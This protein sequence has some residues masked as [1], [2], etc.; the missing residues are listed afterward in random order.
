MNFILFALLLSVGQ[1]L[2]AAPSGQL[3]VSSDGTGSG[4]ITSSPSGI[5]C[6]NI[7]SASYPAG[8]QVSL[9]ANPASG[10]ILA[11]WNGD[12]FG[13]GV[14]LISISSVAAQSAVAT[15]NSE[16][17]DTIPLTVSLSGL[18]NGSV[19]SSPSGINCG[20]DCAGSFP[21]GTQVSLTAVA[22][23]G[24]VFAGW[25]GGGCSGT[26]VCTVSSQ[27]PESVSAAFNLASYP[28]RVSV[29]G[30]GEVTSSPA[31]IDCRA[32]NSGDC[33]ASFALGTTVSLTAE[34]AVGSSFVGWGQ[35]CSGNGNCSIA[36]N[37]AQSVS[38]AFQP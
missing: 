18:G 15:F 11:S 31:G 20:S 4:T 38:A 1:G 6:G 27:S 8:T 19:T 32:G 36:I 3:S 7:C 28:L 10:S 17:S 26:G 35:N 37:S 23:E 2:F 12:C 34:P 14:C 30:N 13:T 9:S 24:S 29:S 33:L 5:N 22:E 25:S 21:P 16:N